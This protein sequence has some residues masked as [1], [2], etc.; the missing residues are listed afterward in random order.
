MRPRNAQ[1]VPKVAQQVF[2]GAPIPTL[3]HLRREDFGAVLAGGG[4]CSSKRR[5]PRKARGL[6]DLLALP[7]ALSRTL[8]WPRPGLRAVAPDRT[9]CAIWT[10]PEL[11]G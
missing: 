3:E 4:V 9:V 1:E 11:P 2:R 7:L 6:Y 10:H 5:A 8:M